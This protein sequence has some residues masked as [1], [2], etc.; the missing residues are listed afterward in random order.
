MSCMNL[1]TDF[2]PIFQ[3]SPRTWQHYKYSPHEPGGFNSSTKFFYK[4][5][6]CPVLK[7]G[8]YNEKGNIEWLT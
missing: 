4:K 2:F 3:F 6:V 5:I 7:W 8:N 1:K